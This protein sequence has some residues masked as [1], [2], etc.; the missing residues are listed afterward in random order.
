MQAD[1]KYCLSN[2]LSAKALM[3]HAPKCVAF[4]IKKQKW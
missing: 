1:Q 4:K 3:T 2:V